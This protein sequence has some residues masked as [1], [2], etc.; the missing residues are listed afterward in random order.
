MNNRATVVGEGA[1]LTLGVI[2][3]LAGSLDAAQLEID[4][5]IVPQ[6]D[7]SITARARFEKPQDTTTNPTAELVFPNGNSKSFR[8]G[9]WSA[10]GTL[11][12]FDPVRLGT[13]H[14]VGRLVVR[15][16]AAADRAMCEEP[17]FVGAAPLL[18]RLRQFTDWMVAHPHDF[19]F[20]EGYYYR[21]LLGLYEITGEK[22]YLDLVREGAERLL[23]RQAA[24]GYWGTGY[25]SVYL[26]DTGSALGLLVNFHKHATPDERKRIELA[27]RRYVEL[28]L[29]KGDSRGNPFVHAD[30]SVG[31]GFKTFRDGKGSGDLNKPYTIATA[32]TGGEIFAALNYLHGEPAHKTIAVKACDWLLNTM[33][34]EGVF[35]TIIE[36]WN[37]GGANQDTL[38]RLYPL[39]AAT[40]VG[41][42][43]VQAW[44]YIDDVAFRQRIERRI[45]PHIEWLLRTQNTDGSWGNPETEVGQ[46]DQARGHGVVNLLAWHY[47]N[48]S[49]DPRVAAAIRRYC[50]LLLDD[51]R[52]SYT[53]VAPAQL[54]KSRW[55]VP[56]EHVGTA[57]AGRA[58]VEVVKPGADCYRWKEPKPSPMKKP[59]AANRALIP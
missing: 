56:L 17:F 16:S 22:R 13:D 31:I 18:A 1:I 30:G 3:L 12:T 47:R 41:E 55:A 59:D 29:V 49:P 10:D 2:V 33:N 25:G 38:W 27:L 53:N 14:G 45:K 42:G 8:A 34:D 6:P 39:S 50:L 57:L 54:A 46:F 26:A 5:G 28:V 11:W 23:R 19:I 32:L 24:E 43:L 51:R 58:L 21:T 40:Y 44:T 20:V 48:V 15:A 4:A 36:D 35:P 37:P 9:R 7:D 52:V